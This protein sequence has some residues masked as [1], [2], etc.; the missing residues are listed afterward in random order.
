MK[1][2]QLVHPLAAGSVAELAD[3]SDLP[4][5]QQWDFRWAVATVSKSVPWTECQ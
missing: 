2:C 1:A 3:Q 4:M 5:V